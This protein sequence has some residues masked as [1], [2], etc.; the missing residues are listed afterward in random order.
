MD[1]MF[2]EGFFLQASLIFALGA[3]NIFV[4]ESGLRKQH[5]LVVS[6]ACFFCDLVLIMLGVAG[7]ATLFTHFPFAKVTI[8]I[9]G[10]LFLFFYGWSK[11]SSVEEKEIG[12]T[13]LVTYTIKQSI[14]KSMAFSLLNPH[15]YL[16]GIV[17]IG[18]YSAKYDELS[19]R[20]TLGFGAAAFSLVWF[21][22]LTSASRTMFPIFKCP[23]RM[24][25]IMCTSGA[26]LIFLSGKLTM[27]VYGWVS[28]VSVAAK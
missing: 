1:Q 7:A 27:D 17:L 3:Q 23:K 9:V 5:P 4:L 28:D 2:F 20:L 13:S 6:F 12:P 8:G 22:L 15:A 11:F 18:G 25:Y 16:D 19:M 10:I 24:R 26:V 21:L 14:L